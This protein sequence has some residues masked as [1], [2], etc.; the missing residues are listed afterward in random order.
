[1]HR[2]ER[3]AIIAL[4]SPS[5]VAIYERHG[6]LT[7]RERLLIGRKEEKRHEG[8]EE[9]IVLG[10]QRKTPIVWAAKKSGI[11]GKVKP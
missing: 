7:T 5:E 1:M 4:L 11:K 6:K 10:R 8:R 9:E 3:D 2:H